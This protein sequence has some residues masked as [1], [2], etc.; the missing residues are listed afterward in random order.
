MTDKADIRSFTYERLKEE[1]TA[2]GEKSFRADQ[3]FD[4]LHVK[5]ADDFEQMTN[6]SKDLRDK[7]ASEFDIYEVKAVWFFFIFPLQKEAKAL[8]CQST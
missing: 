8:S 2:L 1:I 6:L 4:W 5:K 3:I 7:L